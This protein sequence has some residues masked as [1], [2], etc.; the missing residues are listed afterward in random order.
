MANFDLDKQATLHAYGKIL[1]SISYTIRAFNNIDL[2]NRITET[3]QTNIQ[4]QVTDLELSRN[5]LVTQKSTLDNLIN[6][7]ENSL[8]VKRNALIVTQNS[9]KQ[10]ESNLELT[11][12]GATTEA[13]AAQEAAVRRYESDYKTQ[14]AQIMAAQ[15]L[16]ADANAQIAKRQIRAPFNG[17]IT[18]KFF[19]NGEIVSSQSK[20]LEIIS[21]AKYEIT[22]NVPESDIAKIKLD[23]IA[24]LTLDAY[25]DNTPFE[26]KVTKINPAAK[27]I[28]GVPVY[29]VTLNFVE[30]SS[31]IKYGMTA[32]LDIL[33]NKTSDKLAIPLRAVENG[34][35]KVPD[36]ENEKGYSR[37]KVETGLVGTDGFIE[38]KSG[39]KEGDTI[40]TYI[41]E[42]NE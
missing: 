12:S 20:V 5:E 32:N 30:A 4:T 15:A 18:E 11:K 9:I 23:Q 29:E 8:D 10:S 2:S 40:I 42:E 35:V 36:Q 33:T 13:I 38:V 26:A 17:K 22:A 28:E 31:L 24:S 41:E 21:E 19:E 3:I 25:D 16:V 14:Q 6:G 7:Y 1:N 37:V 34:Y 39:L 27:E